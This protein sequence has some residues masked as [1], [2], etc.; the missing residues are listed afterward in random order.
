MDIMILTLP[1]KMR[2]FMIGEYC[3]NAE[4]MLITL[5]VLTATMHDANKEINDDDDDNN[6]IY[7]HAED[8]GIMMMMVLVQ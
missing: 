7:V 2:R 4:V 6:D 5:M 8:N 3:I 1:M